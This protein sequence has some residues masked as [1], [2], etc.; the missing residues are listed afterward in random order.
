MTRGGFTLVEL[1]VAVVVAGILGTALA[2]LLVNDSRFVALQEG[3]L[4]ARRTARIGMNWMV[5]EMRVTTDSG[6]VAASPDSVTIRV[7]YAFGTACDRSGSLLILS[8]V[9]ADS[10]AYANASPDG[11]AW[12][13]ST[14]AYRFIQGVAASAST[15]TAVCT[16]DSIRM[17]PR[18]KCVGVSGTP[19][20]PPNQPVVGS[21]AY[22]YQTVTYKFAPSGDLPGRIG[23]WR[24]AGNSP[25]EELVAPFDTASGFGF[26]VGW[27]FQALDNPP[28]D[29]STVSGLELRIVGASEF[30]PRGATRAQTSDLSLQVRFA[31]LPAY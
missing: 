15:D 11:L 7:P 6:L 1:I 12:R 9:P 19:A 28:A 10:L 21:I 22:L 16:A 20:G 17:V 27:S 26:L 2:M 31:N 3:M 5:S 24:R 29:L 23:L 25:Y 13:Q 14:G 8:L 18:G 30:I 4:S